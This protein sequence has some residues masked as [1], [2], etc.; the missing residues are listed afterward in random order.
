[1]SDTN[2][3]PA[4]WYPAE[5]GQERW[6][7]GAA[8][9][10]QTRPA[11]VTRDPSQPAGTAHPS[12]AP[13]N[14][15]PANILGLVALGIAVL[16]FIFACIPGALIVGWILL[17]IA[18]ILGI[19]AL[20]LK[21]KAKWPAI[22]AIAVSVV[23]TIIGVIVFFAVVA[24][25]ASAAFG[26]TDSSVSE[27]SEQAQGEESATEDEAEEPSAPVGS[28]ENPATIG[29]T[30]TGDEWTVVINSFTADANQMVADGNMF[31]EAPAAGSHYSAV[32]YT[33]TYTGSD[34]SSA[35]LVGLALV[36]STGEVLESFDSLASLPDGMGFDEL[37]T[38]GSATGSTAFLVPDGAEVLIRVTPGMIADDVFVQP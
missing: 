7:D 6:W 12:P 16:G 1:M 5:D 19:V 29:S 26:G 28:R 32:N 11:D 30:I 4:G 22:T 10:G 8:W 25:A 3:T 17:P 21:G 31:N 38:G 13:K 33:V 24:S 37:Y 23:G 18:F 34:S 36:T 2:T 27:P 9:T 15:R 14:K 35:A 20:F